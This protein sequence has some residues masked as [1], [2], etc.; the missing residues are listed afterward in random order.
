MLETRI[1]PARTTVPLG[2]QNVLDSYAV[3]RDEIYNEVI[4]GSSG[5]VDHGDRLVTIFLAMVPFLHCHS[6]YDE[7]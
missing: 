7:H 1:K 6:Q 2:A 3:G 5:I 4:S